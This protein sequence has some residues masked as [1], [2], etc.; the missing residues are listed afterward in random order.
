MGQANARRCFLNSLPMSAQKAHELGLVDEVAEDA[1]LDDAVAKEVDRFLQCG[2]GA[3]A[4]TKQLIRYVSGNDMDAN[5]I[6]TAELLADTW[7]T[8]EAQTGIRCF[9]NRETPPGDEAVRC[10]GCCS[11]WGR[12]YSWLSL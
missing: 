11:Y 10:Q 7:E 5:A 3:V 9:F 1:G 4:A 2:P 8:E 6:Y 12:C